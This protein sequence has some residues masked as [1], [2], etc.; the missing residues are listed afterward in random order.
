MVIG[1]KE[2]H[3]SSSHALQ[4]EDEIIE[5]IFRD[6]IEIMSESDQKE[7]LEIHIQHYNDISS[8]FGHHGAI[9]VCRWDHFI[10]SWFE[11][12]FEQIPFIG[13]YLAVFI[14]LIAYCFSFPF[15]FLYLCLHHGGKG[16]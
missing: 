15:I 9:A 11:I 3:N 5:D 2:K 13:H 16:K 8:V 7:F 4:S 10:H 14:S 1:R 12:P 6:I